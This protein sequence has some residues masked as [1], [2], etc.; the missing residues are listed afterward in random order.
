MQVYLPGVWRCLCHLTED[1]EVQDCGLCGVVVPEAD[2]AGVGPVVLHGHGA[3]GDAD[4][5]TV[6]IAT[7]LDAMVVALPV[8]H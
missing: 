5:P 1:E 3:E 6:N 4:V 2:A 7:E 8:L